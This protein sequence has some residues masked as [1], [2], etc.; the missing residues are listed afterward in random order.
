MTRAG[1]L[2]AVMIKLKSADT[3]ERSSLM[4]FPKQAQQTRL[5]QFKKNLERLFPRRHRLH[6]DQPHIFVSVTSEFLNMVLNNNFLTS[7][8]AHVLVC[9][10]RSSA[11]KGPASSAATAT[12]TTYFSWPHCNAK[13]RYIHGNYSA[14]TT[15]T[16]SI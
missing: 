2:N 1:S 16:E 8:V 4:L 6:Q 10:H 15:R 13:T 7:H 9:F 11:S 12:L 14:R 5:N 3:G